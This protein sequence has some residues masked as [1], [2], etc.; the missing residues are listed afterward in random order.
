M[1]GYAAAILP[2]SE[3]FNAT[4]P[5]TIEFGQ[6]WLA[7]GVVYV[8]KKASR[9]RPTR[10]LISSGSLGDSWY[11]GSHQDLRHDQTMAF[12]GRYEI[13]G[14]VWYDDTGAVAATFGEVPN[15][16]IAAAVFK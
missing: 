13:V 4:D 2:L 7:E 3:Q 16:K 12:L 15:R 6:D 5:T 1:N 10:V 11:I 14:I 8:M 9:T